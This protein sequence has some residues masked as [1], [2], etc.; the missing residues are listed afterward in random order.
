MTDLSLPPLDPPPT[1]AGGGFA[2]PSPPSPGYASVQPLQPARSD[3]VRPAAQ[4]YRLLTAMGEPRCGETV[5]HVETDAGLFLFVPRGEH[6]AVQPVFVP[7]GRYSDFAL[8][9]APAGAADAAA[10]AEPIATEPSVDAPSEPI[11]LTPGP[12]R[13]PAGTLVAKK[14]A[15]ADELIAAIDHQARM[16]VMRIGEALLGLGLADEDQL[17]EAL[18]QQKL[19]RS[20]PLG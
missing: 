10:G 8:Q 4:R 13:R 6:G 11:T 3:D 1:S 14:V 9:T 2:W 20:V 18:A 12:A 15:S 17:G 7:Q 5:G 16:P 19:D